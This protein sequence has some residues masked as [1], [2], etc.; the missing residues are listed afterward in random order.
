MSPTN[1]DAP[2]GSI[3]LRKLPMSGLRTAEGE[4]GRLGLARADGDGLRLR[5]QLL[6]PCLD[7]VRARGEILDRERSV[8]ARRRIER[9]GQDADPGVHPTVHVALEGHHHFR[10]RERPRR[11]HPRLRLADI[12][13]TI[14][15]RHCLDV[16]QDVVAVLDENLLIDH[17]AEHARMIE[18][19][20]LVD[21]HGRRWRGVRRTGGKSALHVHEH[22]A[23]LAVVHDE[24]RIGWRRRVLALAGTL[25]THVDRGILWCSA[26]EMNDA[27]NGCVAGWTG[28]TAAAGASRLRDGTI[29]A[30]RARATLTATTSPN[31]CGQDHRAKHHSSHRSSMWVE[32]FAPP[33]LPFCSRRWARVTSNIPKPAESAIIAIGATNTRVGV[34]TSR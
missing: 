17:R 33:P 2:G 11:R 27:G 9:M 4:V 6:V 29:A 10:L 20:V 34:G 31:A 30:A 15:L 23:E 21:L 26:G 32:S 14:L 25:L 16:V 24:L 8:V 3:Q 7:R 5:A 28:G 22:V 12:E 19:A 1:V 13:R 18:A